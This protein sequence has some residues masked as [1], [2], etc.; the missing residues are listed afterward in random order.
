[1]ARG[2][3]IWMTGLSGAGKSTISD[4]VAK[5]LS[6]QNIKY[7]Q[8]DG[9]LLRN[10][11]CRDLGFDPES[12]GENIRRVAEISKL[13]NGFGIPVLV[14]LISPMRYDRERAKDIIGEDKFVE[15]Y[16]STSL[17]ECEKR[18]VK[19]LYAK[20]RKG[21]IPQFTGVSAPYEPPDNPNLSLNT[22]VMSLEE[23]VNMVM[24][25][26]Q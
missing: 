9:D 24:E 3:T 11:L 22:S 13:L 18:D 14:S 4:A 6:D 1:M 8:L 5:S 15:V 2:I 19:G 23:E 26:L 21:I 20:A 16:V 10:G 17:Q 12:R 25:A 7:V